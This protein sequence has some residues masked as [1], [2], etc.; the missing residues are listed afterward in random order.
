MDSNRFRNS[1]S[2]RLVKAQQGDQSYWAFVPNA[3]PP[4]LDWGDKVLRHTLSNADHSLGELAGL[5]RTLPNPHLFI[6]PFI[7]REAVLSSRIEGTYTNIEDVYFYEA[8]QRPLPGMEDVVTP[9]KGDVREVVNYVR[10]LEFGLEQIR[11]GQPFSLWL[12]R[13]LHS[14]LMKNVRGQESRPG[15]FRQVQNFIGPDRDLSHARYIPPPPLQVTETL[16][17][18]ERYIVRDD[19]EPALVRLA[20]I[21][22]QFEAIH[23]FADGNGRIGRLLLALLAVGWNLLP[24]PLLYLSAYFHRH[25]EEYYDRL[26]AVSESGDWQSWVLFFLQG[27]AEQSRDTVFRAKRMQDLR[28]VW[29]EKLSQFRSAQPQRLADELFLAPIITVPQAQEMLGVRSHRTANT[30]VERL[31]EAGVLHQL[32]G[33]QRPRQFAAV[34]ILKILSEDIVDDNE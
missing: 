31:V 10:A 23:P 34:D 29:R 22:Y 5:G 30:T 12:I 13:G 4:E 19:R 33:P 11:A 7:R 15:E 1:P 27:V 25:R 26:L 14:E 18:L 3:L 17:D 16:A 8:G 9:P 32:P 28:E 24:D 2:G 21:H 6:A 20:F